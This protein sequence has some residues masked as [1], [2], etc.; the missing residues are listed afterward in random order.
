MSLI[1]S[2]TDGL[3]DVDG[4]AATPA[5]RGTDTNTGIFFPAA[6]TIAFSEGGT[7]SMRIDSAGN[8]GIGTASPSGK[9]ELSGTSTI[10]WELTD[11]NYINAYATN[12]VKNAYKGIATDASNH[13][14]KISNSETMRIDTSGNLLVGTTSSIGSGI[15]VQ[16]SANTIQL[17]LRYSGNASGK[18]YTLGS[19][20][21]NGS[22][23]V[24]QS[25]A[26]AGVALVS[27]SATSWS[28]YSDVRLKN[29]TGKIE[30]ALTGVMQLEP[31]KF[32]W[33]KD[34]ENTPQV[35][36]SAQSILPV[37]PEAVDEATNF[38]DLKDDTKYLMVKYTELIPLLAAAIQE[39]NA[40]VDAQAAEIKA[41]KGIAK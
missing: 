26:G 30:N 3:S 4:T 12:P 22:S 38:S 8:V 34:K 21:N 40:K 15:S 13:V 9:L 16:T 29:V 5:I 10:R 6:D 18:H 31:I 37:L 24:I 17:A 33:K 1:L 27:E 36:I 28:A 14:W 11:A 25:N 2:G 19:W 20:S 7:E 35:G 23:F 32:T 41:L 39:L